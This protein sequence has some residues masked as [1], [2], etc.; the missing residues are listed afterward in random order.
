MSIKVGDKVRYRVGRGYGVAT[1][2]VV[3][4]K[5]VVLLTHN[6]KAIVRPIGGELQAVE[7]EQESTGRA[8][9]SAEAMAS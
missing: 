1:A 8:A 6:D 5:Q 4:S 9:S 7:P 2:S 3:T